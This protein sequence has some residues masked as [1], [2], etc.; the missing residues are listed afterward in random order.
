MKSILVTGSSG[1]IGTRLC[2]RLLCDGYQVVGVD[3]APNRWSREIDALTV[4]ADLCWPGSLKNLSTSFDLVIHLAANARVYNLVV[5]PSLAFENIESTFRVLEFCR[6]NEIPRMIFASSREV[7]GNTEG[8]PRREDQTHVNCCESSYTA[9]KMSGETLVRAYGRCYGI[10]CV[11]ARFSNVYGMYDISDRLI[12]LFL[13][14]ARQGRDLIIYGRDKTLDFTYI[15]D[16]VAGICACLQRFDRVADKTFNISS[17]RATRLADVAEIIRQ[18]TKSVSQ[19]V[20]R[21][22]RTGEVERFV[23]DISAARE[24]LGYE[25]RVGINEGLLR[26]IAWY[27]QCDDPDWMVEATRTAIFDVAAPKRRSRGNVKA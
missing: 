6:Q 24:H 23:A 14:R 5:D 8:T 3:R 11:V 21:E 27:A 22:N 7:Y 1:M 20:F 9:S 26:A 15:D 18:T 10:G 12:P 19:V 17:G 2:D 13:R 16:T 25:P 4:A